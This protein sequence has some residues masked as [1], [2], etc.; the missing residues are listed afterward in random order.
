[1]SKKTSIILICMIMIIS[2]I[3]SIYI[4]NRKKIEETV[5]INKNYQII[6][7]S[8]KFGINDGENII[9][10][11]QYDEI[12]IPNSHRAIF[13]CKI[14]S[15]QK[16]IN[17]KNQQIFK[18]YQNIIPI[19]ITE[20]EYEKNVLIYQK[21]EK[22]GLISFSGEIITDAIYEEISSVKYK[23]GELFVKKDGK[24]GVIDQN[25]NNKIKIKYDEIKLDEYYTDENEYKKS[26]YIVKVT[27]EEGYRY[28]YYDNEG[29]KVLQEDFNEI[30]R[31][32]QI[33]SENIYLIAVKKGQCGVYVN[34]SKIINTEYQSIDF[35]TE[36]EMFIVEKTGKFGAINIKGT[37]I[38]DT[39]YSKVEVKGINLYCTKDD[40]QKIFDETGKEV[41]LPF[42]TIIT[43]TSNS[44]YYIRNDSG[45]YSIT[46]K[47]FEKK[48]KQ[49][50]KF[51]E[52][53]YDTYFIVTNEEDKVGV[54]DLNENILIELKYDLIQ[55]IKNKNIIQAIDFATDK[56]DIY[57]SKFDLAL[58]MTNANLELFDNGIK[59]YNNEQEINLDNNGKYISD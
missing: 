21:N 7:K 45:C 48:T 29:E 2:L 18:E 38:L 23:T 46:D 15:E 16:V 37:K 50:Y 26:G 51:I 9:I 17:E 54:I 34:N 49:N 12:I 44:K 41:D 58:E 52:Y 33:R 40:E 32:T 56:T 27:T 3:I 5:D 39:V 59:V 1:M 31:I 53:A 14:G 25:G 43:E 4:P 6:E 20:D 35:N 36:M 8:E 22:Y 28:G 47:T 13:I 30:N 42:E 24:Y 10:E 57:D 55:I 19:Q 11:P